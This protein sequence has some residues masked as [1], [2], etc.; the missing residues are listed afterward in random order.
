MTMFT[1]FFKQ[2]TSTIDAIYMIDEDIDDNSSIF[3]KIVTSNKGAFTRPTKIC[4]LIGQFPDDK[5][6]KVVLTTKG[7]ALVNC[8]KILKK[9]LKHKAGYNVYVRNE[10][11]SAGAIIALGANKII[12]N[13]ESYIGKI[14]PQDPAGKMIIIYATMEDKYVDS[15]NV[16]NVIEARYYLKYLTEIL[17]LIYKK[18]ENDFDTKSSNSVELETV[19][20]HMVYSKLPH[21]KLFDFTECVKTL[22]LNVRK[23]NNNEK[24]YFDQNIVVKQ[25]RK[26]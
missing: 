15:K 19:L 16:Y 2:N 1:G 8:E 18:Q 11:Y 6:I 21:C 14:D 9:L 22:K 10:C 13:D 23:P 25:F 7:G 3:M 12:M 4:E 26:C 20:K 17:R 24:Q 5:V